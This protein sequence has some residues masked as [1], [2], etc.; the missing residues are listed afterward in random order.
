[1]KRRVAGILY[2]GVLGGA[3]GAYALGYFNSWLPQEMKV[4]V[5]RA[6]ILGDGEIKLPAQD[7]QLQEKLQPVIACLNGTATPLRAHVRAYRAQ[8]PELLQDARATYTGKGFKIQVYEQNNAISRECIDK[9]RGAVAMAPADAGLDEPGRIFAD[10]LER[11]I[12]VMNEADTYYNRKD[13]IDDRMEKGKALNGQL[14]PLFDTFFDAE[15]KLRDAVS[16]RNAMLREKQLAAMEQAFGTENF[17]WQTLN[18]SVAARRAMDAVSSL[19]DADQLDAPAVEAIERSYQA[20]FDKADAFAK[21]HPDTKTR[22]GNNPR[23]FSLNAD[24]NRFLVELK[25]LRRS[26]VAKADAQ[27]V[28]ARLAKVEQQYNGMIRTYNMVRDR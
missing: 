24:F 3:M 12:P 7:A 6:S 18:V 15:S 26:L 8:Y 9:L 23:W 20:A 19:A 2:L 22:L 5:S 27:T 14:T 11:L 13:N 25:E 1:M 16:A 4:G 28:Q 21:T 10:T 17:G